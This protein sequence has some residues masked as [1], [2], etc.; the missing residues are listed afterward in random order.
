MEHF[1]IHE[2][3]CKAVC[4]NVWP[5]LFEGLIFLFFYNCSLFIIE[6]PVFLFVISLSILLSHLL[7]DEAFVA[8]LS[9]ASLCFCFSFIHLFSY[10][11]VREY[12]FHIVVKEWVFLRGIF[13]LGSPR[14]NSFARLG[15]SNVSF[16][17]AFGVRSSRQ[18][19]NDRIL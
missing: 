2:N 13:T 19:Q 7:S 12:S 18:L 5:F 14:S 10:V 11:V 6:C 1:Q 3:L 9:S 15:F 16:I 8:V 4:W 17:A